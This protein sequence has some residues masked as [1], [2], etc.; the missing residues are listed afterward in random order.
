MALGSGSTTVPS[1]VNASS[2]GL[3]RFSLLVTALRD[4]KGQT[5]PRM[6]LFDFEKVG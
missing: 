6:D 3:L 2:F 1:T 5:P 4:V